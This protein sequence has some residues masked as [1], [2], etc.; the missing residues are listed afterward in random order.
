MSTRKHS[1]GI[2]VVASVRVG[3]VQIADVDLQSA[4]ISNLAAGFTDA[5]ESGELAIGFGCLQ[6]RHYGCI[7]KH[8][9]SSLVVHTGPAS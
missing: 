3:M 7:D 6:C 4:S 8:L 9:A 5:A 1:V 2:H